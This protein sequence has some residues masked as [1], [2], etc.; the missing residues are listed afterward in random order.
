MANHPERFEDYVVAEMRGYISEDNKVP[1]R[2][3][4]CRKFLD[5]S[6]SE[7]CE[8]ELEGRCFI[9]NIL[10]KWPLYTIL[11]PPEVQEYMNKTHDRTVPALKMLIKE[12]FT[13]TQEID[14]FDRRT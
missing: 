11:L 5:I 9:A 3:T 13:Y 2:E 12:G 4:L 8:M 1:F 14:P 7:L 6:Y 10:P